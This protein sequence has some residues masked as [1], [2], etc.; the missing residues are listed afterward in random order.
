MSAH[1]PPGRPVFDPADRIPALATLR[2]RVQRQDWDGVRAS[3]DALTDEDDRAVASRVVADLPDSEPFLRQAADRA[4]RDPLARTLLADRLIQT[5]WGIRS[6]ARAE[7]VSRRQFDEFHAQL[8]HAEMLLIDVC[9]EHPHYALAWY[10]RLMTSRGLELGQGESRRRYDRLAEHHPH[11]YAGQQQLLQQ[12]CPK[13]SGSWEAAHAFADACAKASPAGSPN[14]ALVAIAQLEQF[15]D[16]TRNEDIEAAQAY[17]RSPENHDRLLAAAA[18]SVLHPDAR[19]DARTDA[20]V[21]VNA[22]CAFAIT[23]GAAL[24][25]EAAAP[26]FRAL[27]DRASEFPWHYLGNGDPETQ[28]VRHRTNALAQG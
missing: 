7:H 9:A 13:W 1:P 15:M 5:A 3:F 26:H 12:L 25:P 22:Y 28:F 19:T 10:L 8:R 23:H 6:R 11:H 24:H 16:V 18:H 27:G 20:Y 14:A 2:D 17:V 21:Q 4:P